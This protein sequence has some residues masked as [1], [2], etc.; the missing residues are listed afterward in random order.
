MSKKRYVGYSYESECQERAEFVAKGIET[1]RRDSC[2]AASKMLEKSLHILFDTED[3]DKVK[4]YV[5][6]QFH[7]LMTSKLSYVSDFIFAK[8]YRGLHNYSRNARVPALEMTRRAMEKDI[9]F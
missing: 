5:K 1:V 3:P 8:E 7:K 4:M 9:R 2:N 6:R